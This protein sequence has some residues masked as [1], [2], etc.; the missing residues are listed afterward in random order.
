MSRPDSAS[1]GE[2]PAAHAPQ[3]KI[4][5]STT[6]ILPFPREQVFEAFRDPARLAR[7]WGPTGFSNEFHEFDLRP[8]GR[9]RFTMVAPDGARIPQEKT[10]LEVERPSRVVL[11]HS[12]EGHDFT[13]HLAFG[14][15]PGGTRLTWRMR[16]ATPEQLAAVEAQVIIGN[17]QNL[18]RLA[19]HLATRR[20]AA[21]SQSDRKSD[22]MPPPQTASDTGFTIERT[23]KA[24]PEK[25]WSM[26]TTKEGLMKWWAPSARNMGFEFTVKEIDVRAGG[27]FAFGMKNAQHDL[28][29]RGTYVVVEPHSHLAWTWHFDIYLGPA[30]KP[31]EVPISVVLTRLPAG[32]TKMTFIQGPLAKAASTEGSRQGVMANF[33]RLA[34][35]LEE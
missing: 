16:F 29:N 31:Y 6:R 34:E 10:F 24:A 25:V 12:Q 13:L 30:E 19:D 32:G 9:W 17:E 20:A 11:A 7:W 27:R 8:G 18:D 5:I 4:E 2:G 33:E 15:A 28:T 14:E 3:P 26:W 21:T 22:T 35:A 1:P 23:F